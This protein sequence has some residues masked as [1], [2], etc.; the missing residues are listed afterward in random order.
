MI[1][2]LTEEE[3]GL[4]ENL[5]YPLAAA[6]CLFSD[7]DNLASM[8]DKNFAHVRL[9]QYPLL[10]YEY[11][12]D[13]E[14]DLSEKQN[15]Q[16]R[17]GAGDTYCMGGRL[18]GKT[19]L[20]EKVDILL[21]FFLNENMSC[22]FSSY[23]AIHIRGVL[24]E[25]IHVL[26]HH[27]IY[28]SFKPSINRSPSY[29]L[30]VNGVILE[31]VNMNITGKK[32]GAQ[33]FQKHFH[34]L[35][36]EEASFETDEVYRQRRDSVSENGCIF[37]IAGM[38][39]FTKHSP[40]GKFFYDL[41]RKPW[42]INL[43][44]YVNPKWDTNE[45]AKAIKDFGGE[46][47]MGFRIFIKGEVV[48]EGVS[49]FDMTRVRECYLENKKVQ[50]FEITKE[51]FLMFE[52][53]LASLEKP[54]NATEAYLSSDIGEAA[55]SELAV[56]FK[57]NEKYR[58]KYNITLYNLTDKEQYKIFKW[59]SIKLGLNYIGLDCTDG[60]GRAI[61]RSL[62][63][64]I[65]KE[66]LVWVGFNEK[67]PVDFDKDEYGNVIYK[68]GKPTYV[69]EYVSIWSVK[70]L[71]Q[72][73]YAGRIELPIDHKF[74]V[75]VN[76]VVALQSGT[77]VKYMCVAQEDHLFQSFQVFAIMQ[78]NCEFLNA[79]AVSGKSFSKTGY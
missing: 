34:K 4:M 2:R 76:S 10:S 57:V 28:R 15:F 5:Y 77:R 25:V 39:N 7:Y 66:N 29:R 35:W 38:T 78:W 1:E 50:Y 51:N 11:I 58:Y 55:P 69:D 44:Q 23:D 63:E 32:P 61:Y 16:I 60:T 37:R 75:Q 3:L 30:Q 40:C 59:L 56:L 13:D 46:Q 27:P 9:G 21:T 20:V 14:P 73:L 48:E 18:F 41:D 71:Q 65:P 12:Y 54:K 70:Y 45:K 68:D 53:I 72:L 19:L 62:E 49:V 6:E 22:G 26:E 42:I 24:E 8:D 31:G 17:K 52:L 74:D 67:I 79:K 43:P 36:I 64:T 33:F 47:S